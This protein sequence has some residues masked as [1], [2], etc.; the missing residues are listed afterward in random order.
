[1][2]FFSIKTAYDMLSVVDYSKLNISHLINLF[3]QS[4]KVASGVRVFGGKSPIFG[5]VVR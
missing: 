2:R 4:I 5:V 3:N 1:M